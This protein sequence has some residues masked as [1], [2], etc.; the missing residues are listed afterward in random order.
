ML[1]SG[2]TF[3]CFVLRHL[4]N[5]K[6]HVSD[7]IVDGFAIHDLGFVRSIIHVYIRKVMTSCG[8]FLASFT[9]PD[10]RAYHV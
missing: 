5:R 7:V 1:D 3:V 2:S 9:E 10:L 4:C 6:D 8:T